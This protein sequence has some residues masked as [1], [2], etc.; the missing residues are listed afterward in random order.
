MGNCTSTRRKIFKPSHRSKQ[1]KLTQLSKLPRL[2]PSHQSSKIT[3]SHQSSKITPSH[4]SSR[5]NNPSGI[6][7]I[8]NDMDSRDIQDL[9]VVDKKVLSPRNRKSA[10]LVGLNYTGTDAALEGCINDANRMKRTLEN[11]F[12]Y[13]ETTVLTD[14]NITEENNILSVLDRLIASKSKTMFFLYSGHGT[15]CYDLDGDESDG[16]DEALYSVN[17]TIIIDDD[18]NKLMT[19]IPK[20]S[21]MILVIDACHSGTMIDL[22][23]QLKG[24]RIVQINNKLMSADVICISGC[25]D[26]QV[27]MDVRKDNTAYGAMSNAFQSV[28]KQNDITKMSWKT[29]IH[30]IRADLLLNQYTQVPQ[31]CVSRA[32]IIN[33]K[34][35]I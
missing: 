31:L 23:Y 8:F 34:V 21:T 12:G 33:M 20:G 24:D 6:N 15:Q 25:S 1:S 4:Q 3:P 19:K 13:T 17:G 29:L 11:K 22:P 18:L 10:V 9:L 28:I 30:R 27:S 26:D 2:S 16:L 5:P 32:E 14:N 7:I 35:N